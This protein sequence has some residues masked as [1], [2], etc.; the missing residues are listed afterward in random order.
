MKTKSQILA[1]NPTLSEYRVMLNED[2]ADKFQIAFDCFADDEDHAEEQAKGAY[3]SSVI[4]H[5][6]KIDDDDL[7]YDQQSSPKG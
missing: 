7:S 5:I 3:P 6:V 2:A 1:D 4:K